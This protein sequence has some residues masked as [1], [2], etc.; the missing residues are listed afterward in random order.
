MSTT[1]PTLQTFFGSAI[2][3]FWVDWTHD[4]AKGTG[5]AATDTLTITATLNLFNADIMTGPGGIYSGETAGY[6][7]LAK[8]FVPYLIIQ[9]TD[10]ATIVTNNYDGWVWPLDIVATDG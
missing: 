3:G 10:P 6:G 4:T 2:Q 8:A 9:N 5:D 1:N 7:P